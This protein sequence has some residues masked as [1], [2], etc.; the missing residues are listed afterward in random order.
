MC[1]Y[2]FERKRVSANER[3][4][5]SLSH[6]ILPRCDV[7]LIL[8]FSSQMRAILAITVHFN[9]GPLNISCL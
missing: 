8:I 6:F 4:I 5:S 1:V 9:F 2:I 3:K 7:P